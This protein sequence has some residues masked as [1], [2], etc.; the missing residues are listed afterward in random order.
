MRPLVVLF[1]K[2]PEP[3]RVKTR[4]ARHV[5]PAPAAV[6]YAAFVWDM[7]HTLDNLPAEVLCCVD[8]THSLT[9][10]GRWLGSM[11]HLLPQRGRDLGERMANALHHA[12]FGLGYE[13]ALLLGTDVPHLSGTVLLEAWQRLRTKDVVLGPALDG[14][15]WLMGM[16]R[17]G[18]NARVFD[19]MPW[20]TRHVLELTMIR[21][22]TAGCGTSLL[23]PLGDV[24]EMHD[25]QRLLD[26]PAP[27]PATR[28]AA[29]SLGLYAP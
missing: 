16:R 8:P 22:V 28:R 11:R 1:C 25:L 6:L 7:L 27:I 24:D 10:Y 17:G 21:L 4:L 3:G 9:D 23:P 29:R 15:Y 19:S 14:G 18:C 5:G 2:Y 12:L 20:S 26:S 13:R